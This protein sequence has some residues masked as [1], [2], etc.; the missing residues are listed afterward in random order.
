MSD[1]GE[2]FP[3][4][5]KP[6]ARPAR[7]AEEFHWRDQ[8]IL[9]MPEQSAIAVYVDAAS[10]DV[11]IVQKAGMT[12]D[13]DHVIFVAPQNLARLLLALAPLVPSGPDDAL[14]ATINQL[15]ERQGRGN[16]HGGD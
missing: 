13:A 12:D 15:I 5:K 3:T 7:K 9:V 2:L 4:S 8:E 11:V 16:L 14:M 10:G 1:N 6:P